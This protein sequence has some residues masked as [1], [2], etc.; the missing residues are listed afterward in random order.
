MLQ[1]AGKKIGGSKRPPIFYY[2]VMINI[3]IN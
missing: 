2:H 1:D 3:I